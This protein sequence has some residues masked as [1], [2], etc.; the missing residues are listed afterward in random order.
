MT[1][2]WSVGEI[3]HGSEQQL[4]FKSTLFDFLANMFVLTFFFLIV[5]V[6]MNF[7]NGLAVSDVRVLKK[8]AQIRNE[9]LRIDIIYH[10]ELLF[11]H[12]IVRGILDWFG[13]TPSKIFLIP[14]FKNKKLT[15]LFKTYGKWRSWRMVELK[16]NRHIKVWMPSK[17][18]KVLKQAL[19]DKK[20]KKTNGTKEY[21]QELTKIKEEIMRKTKEEIKQTKEEI[22][23]KLDEKFNLILQ[24][25]SESE[26]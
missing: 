2:L 3:D 13:A 25:M 20:C 8:D 17:S 1:T 22:M 24:K 15:F 12:P 10:L 19:L 14:E 23:R 5:L 18:F 21:E 4:K 16:D 6:F 9:I 7:L 26:A 11:L